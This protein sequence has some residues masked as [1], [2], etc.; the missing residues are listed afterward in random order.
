MSKRNK[1]KDAENKAPETNNTNVKETEDMKEKGA[2]R[3]TLEG[4]FKKV[5]ESKAT[6]FVVGGLVTAT[7]VAGAYIA[8]KKGLPKF[9]S[10]EDYDPCEF[11]DLDADDEES[12]ETEESEN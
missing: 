8:G 4:T 9:D 12:D 3:T 6:K 7:L 11:D 2:I 1:K 5:K 10:D